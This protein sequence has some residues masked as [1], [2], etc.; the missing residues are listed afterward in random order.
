MRRGRNERNI[1]IKSQYLG[2]D[3]RVH[4]P[5]RIT[6]NIEK[7]VQVALA[8]KIESGSHASTQRVDWKVLRE[9]KVQREKVR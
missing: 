7:R 6:Q 5:K 4:I 3:K 2:S 1:N 9:G 8:R